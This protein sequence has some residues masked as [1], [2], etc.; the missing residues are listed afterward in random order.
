MT[1]DEIVDLVCYLDRDS[2]V[3]EIGGGGSTIF[4]SRIVKKLITI[5]HSL[6]W[7]GK[8]KIEMSN[9]PKKAD[10]E[11]HTIPPSW[12]QVHP[13]HPAEPGQFDSYVEFISSLEKESFDVILVDGRDRVRCFE[14]SVP[15]LKK[16]GVILVHDFW[17]REKYHSM[18]NIPGVSLII[19]EKSSSNTLAA[20]VKI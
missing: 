19:K 9:L 5:E 2:D 11:I 3:L 18:L 14:S 20:F 13:F 12:S 8:I 17:N 4:I 10:W 16:G 15:L 6:E 7:A 1:T